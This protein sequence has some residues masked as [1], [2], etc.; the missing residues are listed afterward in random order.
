MCGGWP[1]LLGGSGPQVLQL[2]QTSL[3]FLCLGDF[4]D[5]KLR[6]LSR[7][8]SLSLSRQ[9]S[10]TLRHYVPQSYYGSYFKISPPPPSHDLILDLNW[11]FF[12]VFCGRWCNRNPQMCL[13]LCQSLWMHNMLRLNEWIYGY[14]PGC[15]LPYNCMLKD[16]TSTTCPGFRCQFRTNIQQYLTSINNWDA[17]VPCQA[18][19]IN[20]V[21]LFY[22]Y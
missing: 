13:N 1:S 22:P 15:P 6:Y 4:R 21:Q 9:F 16:S 10:T 19:P 11:V 12:L 20:C 17:C 7:S 18:N 14:S 5:W 3:A 8:P 2:I